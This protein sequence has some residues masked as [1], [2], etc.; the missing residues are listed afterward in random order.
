MQKLY[1]VEYSTKQKCFH[2]DELDRV[3]KLNFKKFLMGIQNDWQIIGIFETM[4]EADNFYE[5]YCRPVMKE[6]YK[7]GKI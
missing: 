2:Q 7:K 3:E 5:T 4:E 1:I 6:W